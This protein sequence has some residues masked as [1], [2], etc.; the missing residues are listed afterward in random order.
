MK[1]TLPFFG[2]RPRLADLIRR[3]AHQGIL[4]E[5]RKGVVSL[6]GQN[7]AVSQ[8]QDARSPRRLAAQIPSALEQLP[9]QLEGDEGLAGAGGERQQ[10]A[11]PA[12]GDGFERVFDGVV[13][14]V[15]RLP[16][17]ALVLEGD[18][19]EAVA[20]CVFLGEDDVPEV[21]R[22][23]VL[24]NVLLRARLHVDL[25]DAGA[26]GRIGEARLQ[27][28]GVFLRLAHAFGVG[29]IP[30]LG[31]DHGKLVVAVGQHIVGDVLGGAF[32]GSL[33]PS[34]GDDL[35]AHPA[36]VHHAPA[37]R[38]QGGVDQLGAG[39]GLVHAA[40]ASCRAF[41]GCAVSSP[42]KAFCRMACFSSARL[43]SFCW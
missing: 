29:Q 10:N 21:F 18:G 15:A 37:R 43:S 9:R 4:G 42:A 38:L 41:S 32:A 12:V 24:R 28:R 6:I 35:T 31:L 7:V 2:T 26:I 11:L 5:S 17:P 23:R 8:E 20:P 34:E 16:R 14:V 3:D 39:F 13:L 33:Q 40:A 36:C 22:A 25:I 19:G 27:L 1:K 30:P